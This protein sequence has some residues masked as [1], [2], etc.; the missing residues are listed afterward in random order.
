MDNLV[1]GTLDGCDG[2]AFA[3]LGHFSKLAKRQGFDKDWIDDVITE[4][5]RGDY[6]YLVQI[7][8]ENMTG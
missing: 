3:L 2:N 1:K 4:A 7:L 5:K 8:S 6:E